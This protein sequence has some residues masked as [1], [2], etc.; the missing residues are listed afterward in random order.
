[1]HS[2][3][4]KLTKDTA[5]TIIDSSKIIAHHEDKMRY[6]H[7]ISKHLD[8]Y[9]NLLNS[10]QRKDLFDCNNIDK[11]NQKIVKANDIP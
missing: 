2:Q 1:M 11:V 10:S 7:P 3:L 8:N 5:N 4:L 6:K 9:M